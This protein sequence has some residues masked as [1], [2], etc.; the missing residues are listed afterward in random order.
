MMDAEYTTI[1]DPS[2][3]MLGVLENAGDISYSLPHNDLWTASFTLPSRDPKNGYCQEDN[4]VHL[5]D[6][7]RDIGIYRIV[8]M[9]SGEETAAGGVR[10]Y[11]L[12]HVMATLLD[13]VL[14][15]YHEVGGVSVGT[16]QVMQ[17]ILAKQSVQRWALGECDFTD[18]Y[19]YKFENASLLSAL[20]SLGGV[21]S[22]EY[23]WIF[24]TSAT[25][26]RV[27][28]KRADATAGCG[29]HYMRSM[30]GVEKSMDAA[31]K[32]TRLYLLGYG[33][34]VNQLTIKDVNGGV[35][36]L[37]AD[38][39]D[40]SHPKCSVFAD[41]RIEDANTL[42]AR[43][44]AV[45]NLLKTPY[46]SYTATAIDWGRVTGQSWDS[47][48]PGKLVH[49]MD[50]EH[51]IDFNARI[52]CIS[53]ADVGG[54]PGEIVIEV[55]NQPRDVTDSI[56]TLADRLG[57]GELYSQGATNLYSQQYADNADQKHPAIMRVYVPSGCVRINQMLLSWSTEAFRAY[58]T[59]AAAGGA[60]VTSTNSAGQS[61]QTSSA[62]GEATITEPQKVFAASVVMTG[63]IDING[64]DMTLTDGNFNNQGTKT[65]ACTDRTGA[66]GYL[67]T[68]VNE[69][70]TTSSAGGGTTGASDDTKNSHG[71]GQEPNHKHSISG[72]STSYNGAHRHNV[73][74][75]TCSHAHPIDA[76]THT[77]GAHSHLMTSHS[78]TLN[79]H[80]HSISVHQHGMS[81]KHGLSVGITI[82]AMTI[83]VPAHIHTVSVPS[84]THDLALADH[85]HDISFGIYEGSRASGVDVY[86]DNVPIPAASL[87]ASEMDIVGYLAKDK[88]GKITRGTWHEIK[89]VP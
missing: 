55:A 36:Y 70:A 54:R 78:H 50:G 34:G 56:N 64:D 73:F 20:L 75:A 80:L 82:P 2:G 38:N 27:S 53:K 10:T 42:K 12:E 16:A 4:R 6:G 62:G 23:T 15:G 88:G 37:D 1:Y 25:P 22:E 21:I 44:L 28:L 49:V 81:H 71:C 48:M 7:T 58:E 46:V 13:D 72:S 59:G 31:T 33:E 52:K 86:V 79:D 40:P 41:T 66:S 8:A 85:V 77:V 83:N 39:I 32:V 45:L 89:I 61:T 9:P 68:N 57:I 63:P 14:F 87:K 3:D 18:Q 51:G 69:I 24:D 35:P 17:Y 60:N 5:M 43:G 74:N 29:I 19:T 76:H 65:D 30:V 26:W 11:N 67:V 84:H 47:Y